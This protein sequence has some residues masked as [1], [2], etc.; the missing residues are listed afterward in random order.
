MIHLRL[1]GIAL[2]LATGAAGA[3]EIH[4]WTD[5]QGR[6]HFGDRPPEAAGTYAPSGTEAAAAA[7]SPSEAER[8]QR[9]QKMLD[10]YQQERA[11]RAEGEARQKAEEAERQR[12][13]A[14]ARDRLARYERGGRI[15][16]PLPNG[17]QRFLSD[18]ERD[19][20]L[21]TARNEVN[22][23]CGKAKR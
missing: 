6:V 3:Q 20:E 21:R 8:A 13:C 2:A 23:Y 11:D 16:E 10:A 19:A 17:E 12:R 5:A 22:R 7:A 9:R 1:A 4:R 15:Y 14:H 18:D